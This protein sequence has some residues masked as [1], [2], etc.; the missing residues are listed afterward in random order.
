MEDLNEL[1][2]SI[3]TMSLTENE[4][5][6]YSN[7]ES[8]DFVTLESRTD[9]GLVAV[10]TKDVAVGTKIFRE[11]PVLV[12]EEGDLSDLF[13][14]F[15]A[16]DTRSKAS[17]LDMYDPRMLTPDLGF[18][19]FMI[20]SKL[21]LSP[22]VAKK[23]IAIDKYTSKEYLISED[24]FYDEDFSALF[25]FSSKVAH[26]CN[27][28]TVFTR[29][30]DDGRMECR[31]VRS[32]QAGELVTYSLSG[33]LVEMPQH[34]KLGISMLEGRAMLCRC[35][36]CLGPDYSR[37]VFCTKC[38]SGV[39]LCTNPNGNLPVWSCNK[40]DDLQEGV[41]RRI[42]SI[43]EEFSKDLDVL[44]FL[45]TTD[46]SAICLDKLKTKI[47]AATKKLHLHHFITLK[48]MNHYIVLCD[49]RGDELKLLNMLGCP[50]PLVASAER[51]LGTPTKNYTEAA[52]MRVS[53]VERLECI[54]GGCIDSDSSDSSTT[55]DALEQTLVPFACGFAYRVAQQ[56]L[57][58]PSS[59][60]PA[61]GRDVVHRYIPL[62]KV[63]Y[64][65]D[66]DDIANI[67]RKI[68]PSNVQGGVV[69]LGRSALPQAAEKKAKQRRKRRG[70]TNKKKKGR[71]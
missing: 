38:R 43:E 60:W 18:G 26:S 3:G 9:I 10:A 30:T 27:P 58:C 37:P 55:G 44:S 68:V 25:L 59:R 66:N 39:L 6:L 67:E 24:G 33:L 7:L 49:S 29:R 51:E 52:E 34:I 57:R 22:I 40:C 54:A 31:A 35:A 45:L 41:D 5:F 63:M 32:I 23:L 4:S 8:A 1:N 19:V 56:M 47:K 14:S 20:A 50:R 28:N 64:G 11:K 15:V 70:R 17:V 42:A 21:S 2:Q 48:L 16:L 36:L 12:Y 13:S 46:P 69:A 61:N 65:E 53:Y 71:R 62:M